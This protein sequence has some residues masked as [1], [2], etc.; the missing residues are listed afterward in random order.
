MSKGK[1]LQI[2][3]QLLMDA[4]VKERHQ[5]ANGKEE[6]NASEVPQPSGALRYL[7]TLEHDDRFEWGETYLDTQTGKIRWM[8]VGADPNRREK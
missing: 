4:H 3:Q 5:D 8:P 1:S 7:R 2:I 6:R